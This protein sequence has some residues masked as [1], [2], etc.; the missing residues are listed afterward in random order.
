MTIQREAQTER[1][2]HCTKKQ[3]TS[4]QT[5]SS[6]EI[7]SC[8]NAPIYLMLYFR[9]NERFFKKSQFV[10]KQGE[11]PWGSALCVLPHAESRAVTCPE[12]NGSFVCETC[13][14]SVLELKGT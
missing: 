7:S 1:C 10:F 12:D 14:D 8:D 4:T 3:N 5:Q 2:R 11:H 13:P 6:L 9:Q